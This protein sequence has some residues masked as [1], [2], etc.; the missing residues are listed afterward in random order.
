M[1]K[2]LFTP[3]PLGNE[4]EQV[5]EEEEEEPQKIPTDEMS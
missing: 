1:D 4:E 5:Q 2:G 3:L